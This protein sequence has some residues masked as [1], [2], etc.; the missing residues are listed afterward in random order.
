MGKRDG[1]A[2]FSIEPFFSMT[3]P[4]PLLVICFDDVSDTVYSEGFSYMQTKN[5]NGTAY[6]VSDFIGD[7]GY[8]SEAQLLEMQAAGWV[9]GN[10]SKTHTDFTTLTQAQQET[11]L[12]GCRDALAAIGITTG[13]HVAYPFGNFN[14]DT[15]AAMAAQGMVTGRDDGGG[16]FAFPPA[17]NYQLAATSV[18]R[19]TALATVK[20]A[21]DTAMSNG[22]VLV[23]LFHV[24]TASPSGDYDW[25]ISDF[26]ALMN[27]IHA[28]GY[29]TGTIID[30]YGR[31]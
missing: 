16:A 12:D 15:L 18:L 21:I 2:V 8:L 13:D 22:Q 26:Q 31:L 10:H 27:Y 11:E 24:L 30:L 3:M 6:M 20:S 1:G 29:P 23:L 28:E 17:D 4:N 7:A 14:A 9:I 25:S 19:T 5:I